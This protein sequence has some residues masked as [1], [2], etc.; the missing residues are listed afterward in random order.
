MTAC[1]DESREKSTMLTFSVCPGLA[2]KRSVDVPHPDVTSVSLENVDLVV[3]SKLYWPVRQ[4]DF[5]MAD[6]T[7]TFQMNNRTTTQ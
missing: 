6:S 7:E 5:E 1:S 2:L 4:L 3:T